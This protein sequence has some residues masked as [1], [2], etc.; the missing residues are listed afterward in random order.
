[1]FCTVEEGLK[2]RK[3]L[4]WGLV[5]E[6]VPTSS[7]D[8][9]VRMRAVESAASSDRPVDAVGVT[10][11]PLE[12]TIEGDSIRYRSVRVDI[13][14]DER[15][16]SVTLLGPDSAPPIGG[17]EA[18]QQGAR[19]WPLDLAREL[20][21]AVLHL[22]AN[23][24]EIGSLLIRSQGDLDLVL[25]Y[26]TFLHANREH[27]FVREV[28]L[29]WQRLLKRVDLTA[30]TIL[31]LIEP[32][33][34]FG[35]FLADLTL[36][37]DRSYMLEGSWSGEGGVI[38]QLVFTQS[39]GGDLRMS[40]GLTRMETRFW[41]DTAGLGVAMAAIGEKLDAAA[42]AAAGLVTEIMDDIDWEDE[43]RIVIEERAAF[44]PDG[45]TG[46]E[47]NLRFAGPETM[48]TKIFGRLSAWQ[49]WVFQRPNASGETGALRRYGTGIR[50]EYDHR[51]V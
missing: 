12:R 42:A 35:G 25:A 15:T 40:N 30:R 19:F 48:E 13:D 21:D 38:A 32:G 49:N 20:D 11:T 6:L 8:E 46:L 33:S 41:G 28:Q 22:R 14:R 5:D 7:F 37:A 45:L 50:P 3:A 2:G 36:A 16:A 31:A 23:E 44:S 29:Y 24:L 10:L 34:C 9:V 43:L 1:V 39:S 17:E 51:R 26:D 4:E 47:A 27:W 18:R